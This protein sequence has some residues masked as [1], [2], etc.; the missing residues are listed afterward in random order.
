[1]WIDSKILS[2]FPDNLLSTAEVEEKFLVQ[3]P[4]YLSFICSHRNSWPLYS[5]PFYTIPT[6]MP[7]YHH[8]A[9]G[10][11][12]PRGVQILYNSLKT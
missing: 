3:N 7:C 1:M 5:S 9:L 12:Y 11:L 8:W 2:Y 10:K 6:C 4:A